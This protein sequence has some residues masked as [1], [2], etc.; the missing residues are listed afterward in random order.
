[1]SFKEAKRFLYDEYPASSEYAKLDLA[2]TEAL[3]MLDIIERK[4]YDDNYDAIEEE[5]H[6]IREVIANYADEA[7][8]TNS[9]YN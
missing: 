6:M 7:T 3:G 8:D 5:E 2:I 1:M 9:S 4:W